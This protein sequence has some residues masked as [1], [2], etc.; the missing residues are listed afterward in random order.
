M[1]RSIELCLTPGFSVLSGRCSHTDGLLSI[2]PGVSDG[3]TLGRPAVEVADVIRAH[4]SELLKR[5]SAT[6][7]AP[8]R[9]TL[10]DLARCR[11]AALGGHLECCRDC[12]HE[13]PAYNSCRNR[14]CPK[15]QAR[16]RAAWLGAQADHLLPVEYYHLVFTLPAELAELARANPTVLYDLLFRAAAA[17]VREV[18]ANPKHLGVCPGLLL[19][20]HTWG[21]TLQL[22]PHVHGVVTGGGLSCG[23]DGRLD[24]VPRW[25]SCRPSFFLPVRVLGRV[26]RGK[27]LAGLREAQTRGRLRFA[28]K[29]G[30]LA[31]PA[32]FHAFL[33]PLSRKD[34]VVY[35]KPPFGGPV[36]VLQY[37]ARYVRRVAISNHRLVKLA[38]GR[39]TFRYTDYADRGRQKTMELDAVE[40]LRRFVQHVLPPGF[41]Q[42]RHYG[43]L[44]TRGLRERL[45]ECRRLLLGAWASSWAATASAE[46]AV[47]PARESCC[48]VCGSRRLERRPLPTPTPDTS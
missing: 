3:L 44:A 15:C 33:R 25:V 14:H 29:Y 4:G 10:R 30:P 43:L 45:A 6:F 27:Y 38:A 28:G 26:F 48:V 7:C 31:D 35:A 17:T 2:A 1:G 24:A 16:S 34:W 23:P 42:V 37:L 18:A 5:F 47:E 13:R 9:R 21:Q 8:Q 40:F 20:L 32:A 36:R 12:G 41:V 11:T 39:V 19:V 22:H 46:A